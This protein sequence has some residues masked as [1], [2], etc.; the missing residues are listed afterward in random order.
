[1]TKTLKEN[2]QALIYGLVLIAL[3]IA[4]F[5][6]DTIKDFFS[7]SAPSSSSNASSTATSTPSIPSK[8]LNDE[9]ILSKGSSGE[10]V[11]RLQQLLNIKHGNNKPQI[12]PYLVEDGNFGT[13]TESMLKKWT[14]KTSISINQLIKALK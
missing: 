3:V 7:K 8:T 13:A 10:Q 12:I 2:Q 14:G 5:K 11:L 6:R 9:T 1:M 4:Y